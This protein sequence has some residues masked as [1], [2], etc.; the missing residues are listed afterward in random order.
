MLQFENLSD[1]CRDIVEKYIS[2]EIRNN[3]FISPM[4]K[5]ELMASL[6][7]IM[8]GTKPEV[9]KSLGQ[10]VKDL[11]SK[12]SNEEINLLRDEYPAVMQYCFDR[13]VSFA[14]SVYS[15]DKNGYTN[16][17]LPEYLLELC[18]KL[19]SPEKGDNVF[20]PYAG[21]SQIVFLKPEANYWGFEQES[22]RWALSQMMLHAR[23]IHSS[24]ILTE[25]MNESLPT[26][27]KFDYIFSMPPFATGRQ[28]GRI[29]GNIYEL[30]TKHLAENGNLCC[31][32]PESFCYATSGWFDVRKILWDY[33][34]KYSII[35]ITLPQLPNLFNAANLC[36]FCLVKDGKGDILLMDASR[37]D[38]FIVKHDAIAYEYWYINADSILDTIKH[39]SG[40]FCW[41]GK[42]EDLNKDVNLTPSRYLINTILPEANTRKG[43]NLYSIGDLIELVP[44]E[45]IGSN[46]ILMPLLG[47]KDLSENYLNCDIPYST[48]PQKKAQSS[49]VLKDNC[50][51]VGFIGGKF[52]VGRSVELSAEYSIALRPEIIPFR[53]KNKEI[54][55]EFLLR[56]F[57][58]N[59]NL[60]EQAR[61]LSTGENISRLDR[62]DFLNLKIIVPTIAEQEQVAK[63]DSK[64]I[65]SEADQSLRKTHEEFR[66]DMHMKKHAIGQTIFNLG[67][68]WKILQRARKEGNGIVDDNAVIGRSHKIEVK[69]IYD[70]IQNVIDQLQVQI[71]KFDRG[72]GL[73]TETISLTTFIEDYIENHKSPIFYFDYDKTSH[74][75]TTTIDVEIVYDENGKPIDTKGGQEVEFTFEDA[76]FA[77]DALTIIFDNIVSN[78]CSHGFVGREDNPD[79]NIIKIDLTTEGTDHIITISNNGN[80]VS[81]NVTEEY[82]FTY[83]SSTRNG[84]GHYGIG[85]YEVKRLMQEFDGDAEFISQP[86]AEFPVK[87]KL[88]FHNTGIETIDLNIVE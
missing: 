80:P 40:D 14:D 6:Y 16:K 76:V 56:S 10:S 34:D 73:T 70:N 5:L 36:L 50:L 28:V 43:E 58:F 42:V 79:R 82:V 19:F 3:N 65:I 49:F 87:Y 32:L 33:R 46:D 13:K 9:L 11:S 48:I 81:E 71:N 25:N 61:M 53:L 4:K 66:R 23:G 63:A 51:L 68:W 27:I 30:A 17:M 18:M 26:D 52:K 84:K 41:Y 72:N 22:E 54:S 60:N 12:L 57:L 86:E 38:A 83:N 21:F 1:K 15:V 45:Y 31:I 75:Y 24:I 8:D 55:E 69:D 7:A 77:P 88:I 29:V 47:M 35:V 74:Y 64:R 39:G 62:Q 85:G 2:M 37:N 78:A 67:N 59:D 44:T 20:L